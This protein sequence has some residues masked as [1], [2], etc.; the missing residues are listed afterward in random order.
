MSGVMRA[1]VIGAGLVLAVIGAFAQNL[2]PTEKPFIIESQLLPKAVNVW[3]DQA[4]MQVLW[5]S[6][7]AD[8]AKI[9][10][11]VQGRYTPQIA[12]RLLL[13]GSG[14]TYILLDGE[15]V[16]IRPDSTAATTTST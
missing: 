3:A 9:A 16:S 7:A 4:G 8:T 11:K 15:T 14:L 12:L 6:D 5:S 1:V 10:P 13:Q 2:E